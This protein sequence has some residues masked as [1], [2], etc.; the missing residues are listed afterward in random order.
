MS[1][2]PLIAGGSCHV[3]LAVAR[4]LTMRFADDGEEAECN[5]RR[6]RRAGRFAGSRRS[7]TRRHRQADIAGSSYEKLAGTV[8]SAIDPTRPRNQI[9][10]NLGKAPRNAQIACV[11]EVDPFVSSVM[12]YACVPPWLSGVSLR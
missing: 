1:E 4:R 3:P 11:Y 5:W 2:R 9:V 6:N 8:H 7:H 10:V 12:Q